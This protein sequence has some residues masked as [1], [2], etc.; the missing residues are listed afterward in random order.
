MKTLVHDVRRCGEEWHPG[1]RYGCRV[2]V[3]GVR[4]L[5]D[6]VHRVAHWL[7]VLLVGV[8]S[9]IVYAP[10]LMAQGVLIIPNPPRP[11]PL[12][13]P[14]PWPRPE[15]PQ[16]IYRIK[17]LAVEARIEDQAA[18]VQITQSFVNT[19]SHPMEVRF[20]FPLPP[21]SSVDR[22]TFL[23][24]GKEYDGRLLSA[25]EARRIYESYVRQMRDPALLEWL[26]S[27][28]F[29][30]SVF[31]VPPG[32]E[33]K[34]ILRYQQ[35]LR[36]QDKLVQ[37]LVPLATAKYTSEPIESVRVDVSLS[38][39]EKL[40][41]LYSP[42][43]AVN[44][45]RPDAY[46][47]RITF[48]ARQAIPT[49]DFQLL[50]DVDASPV[51]ASVL[52][53]RPR[54]DEDGYFLLLATPDLRTDTAPVQRKT[55]VAVI[56]RS[57]S[58]SGKKIEQAKEALKFIINNLREGDLFNIVVYDSEVEAFQPELQR[59]DSKSREAA[60]AFVAGIYS[61]GSTNI[62][63]ALQTAFAML[64]DA[65]GPQYVLFLTDGLPTTGEVNEA[66]IAA[67]ARQRNRT[68][69]RLLTFGVGYDVNSRLLDRLAVE[70]NGVSTY[71]RP[72]E[73]IE[74]A[75]AYFY[76]RIN[77]PVLTELT[78]SID[79]EGER[80]G[81]GAA[82]NRV[83]PKNLGDLFAGE[84]LV[85]VGRYRHGGAAKVTLRGRMGDQD[86]TFDFPAQFVNSSVDQTYSFVEKLWAVRRVG[87]IIDE[88]DLRG[89]NDEL[90]KELVE[91]STK[92]GILTPYTSFLA[93]EEGRRHLAA[94][95][96]LWDAAS[97]AADRLG[98]VSG[99]AGVAQRRMKQAY[100]QA[101]SLG[102]LGGFAGGIGGFGGV[103]GAARSPAGQPPQPAAPGGVYFQK[104]DSDTAELAQGVRQAGSQTLY[105]RG[106]V[107][108]A[109]NAQD[110]DPE[111]DVRRYQKVKFLS[112]EYF[113]LLRRTT[114]EENAVL[115]SQLPGEKL[116][117]RLGGQ[118]YLIE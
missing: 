99:V 97:A 29:Q 100:R 111:K 85:V 9:G 13:R 44:I 4:G 59:Y 92:H 84:Q 91:L 27:G 69:A 52:S 116:L 67:N 106:D 22:M 3:G 73:D 95:E 48:E 58:M 20:V 10:G 32:A 70:N 25:S 90:I 98:E 40:K 75:V 108:V 76:S 47:A 23:V 11:I 88:L 5:G 46:H 89:K 31:P 113:R 8:L 33:R 115:A 81:A 14:I 1:K 66:K 93:E 110:I 83:Y 79:I 57:G 50:Y 118:A 7:T 65:E 60:L 104:M 96:R 72:D 34:V 64:R 87:E 105:Q 15:P 78:L 63:G 80:G 39:K 61:G 62:D 51:G 12:P 36:K 114:P 94:R 45:Q 102:G 42:T 53:Y 37:F 71:V 17:E 2:F 18:R 68:K 107:W 103:P 56:D 49:A 77:A 35:L 41:N 16:M 55:V 86:R 109:A 43:Y 117:V 19:G 82:I 6:K 38:T 112:D 24:D 30:T 74:R 28:M 21:D 101:E 54:T 26:G